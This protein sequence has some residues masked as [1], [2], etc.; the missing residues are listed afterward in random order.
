MFQQQQQQ[1]SSSVSMVK[2]E[3]QNLVLSILDDP[4][5]SR[6]FSES[7]FR[8]CDI[9]L[10]ILRP[11]HHQLLRYSRYRGPPVFL[12]NL[13]GD[14]DP[15][16]RN[17]SFP[18]LGF[19]GFSGLSN[20]DENCKRIGEVLVRN[21]GRNPLLVGVCANDAFHSFCA[22]VEKRKGGCV[23]PVEIYGANVIPLDIDVSRFVNGNCDEGLVK[24]RFGEISRTVEHCS[25]PGVLISYGDLNEL[26]G[27]DD[28]DC[29]SASA[30]ASFVVGELTRLVNQSSEGKVWLIGYAATYETYLKF[31]N[32]YP[33][34]EK[35]WDL[36]LLPI[37]SLRPTMGGDS[38]PRSSLMESFVPFGGL[39]STPSD[40]K[41]PLGVSYQCPSRCHLCNEKCEQEVS[42]FA[43][44][45]FAASVAEQ[46][47]S[48]LP[49]WLQMTELSTNRA[50]DTG[51]QTKDDGLA[52]SA[53]VEGLQRKW[54]NICKRLHHAEKLTKGNIYQVGS[55][56]PTV[57]GF[58]VNGDKKENADNQSSRETGSSNASGS[59]K[60][61]SCMSMDTQIFPRSQSAIT[62]P[63]VVSRAL[64][65][66]SLA[67]TGEKSLEPRDLELGGV[68]SPP[69]SLSSSDGH[70]S[71]PSTASVT[72][73]LGLGIYA[74]SSSCTCPAF[75]GVFD[76][77]DFKM[78][79]QQL[80]AR[81]RWQ[82]EALSAIS[83]A[84][85]RCRTSNEPKHFGAS[86]R[87]DIWFTFLGPDCFSK[88]RIAI[89]LAEILY[90]S[91][92][93][94]ICVDISSQDGVIGYDVK[95][96]GKTVVD[97]IVGELSKEPRSVVF[98]ENI[99]E[100]DMTVQNS[101]SQAVKTGKFSDSHGR[102]V[103]VSNAIFVT[104]SRF[105][106]GAE[107]LSFEKETGN[108]PE[109]SILRAKGWPIQIVIDHVLP[110][111]TRI[112]ISNPVIVNKRKS[113][114]TSEMAKRAHKSS[115]TQLDLNLPAEEIELLNTDCWKSGGDSIPLNNKAWLEKFVE[116][117][118]EAVVFK[119]FD[120]D[121][122]AE[123]ISKEISE[124][125]HK[126]VGSDSLLEIDSKVM[127]QI[128]AAACT[129]EEQEA[130]DWVE[131][132]LSRGFVEAQK[133]YN[134]TSG[135]Y[136]VKLVACEGFSSNAEAPG[137]SLPSKILVK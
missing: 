106:K 83:Q 16:P 32:R 96:R 107:V 116:L 102:E 97:Y 78:L 61:A 131:R 50:L 53:K 46:Y 84:I 110:N 23:L 104:T 43:K 94:I 51:V 45:G 74:Q 136:V 72:T 39:F 41:S 5:V 68:Q 90:G 70:A 52:L 109:E 36:Q 13:N 3:L 105:T 124:C 99:D 8:S 18:F 81:I 114:G 69:L 63:G 4:V 29:G 21:K 101:L 103:G 65:L 128:I 117:V 95:F 133:R 89:S 17:F 73:D 132:V 27:D 80:I 10:A 20:G 113:F 119:P 24:L 28:D 48:S 127:E 98:L 82:D 15:G 64:D 125:F 60:V 44:G 86:L 77:R 1:Q 33:S 120:F 88:K 37:T 47:Q 108:Y 100:A 11:V 38:Y 130:K 92:R 85:A 122:L 118:D 79:Y 59:K 135:G 87:G 49:P 34:V 126:I 55:Q 54:N 111:N 19:S 14:S 7:G 62:L 57:V 66:N 56:V 12:C 112:G 123:K 26:I 93:N 75:G 71:P 42:A 25:G 67:K 58:R 40:L 9:K 35:D 115:N 2:V 137:V 121:K 129:F 76:Q 22:V 134:L 30:V 6:V 91:K 31:L